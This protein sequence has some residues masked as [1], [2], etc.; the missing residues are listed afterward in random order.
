M[1][2]SH[3]KAPKLLLKEKFERVRPDHAVEGFHIVPKALTED[4]VWEYNP[5]NDTYDPDLSHS[6][7]IQYKPCRIEG[8]SIFQGRFYFQARY[9]D[10]L[11]QLVEKHAA[12]TKI[13]DALVRLVRKNLNHLHSGF[14]AGNEALKLKDTGFQFRS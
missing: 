14:Y 6:P 8:N 4:I 11:G 10:D 3:S 12:F 7:V 13:A 9:V 1:I 5:H 2:N